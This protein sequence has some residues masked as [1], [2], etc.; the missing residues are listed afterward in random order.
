MTQTSAGAGPGSTGATFAPATSAPSMGDLRFLPGSMID[1]R[2]RIIGLLG[3]GG[4]G[5]VY[6]A[7]DLKLGQPVAL[8]FLPADLAQDED[9]LN[10]FL[11]EVK[12]ARQVAHPNVCRVYD[13]GEAGGSHYL[14]MEYV[15]GEDLATLLRRIG[16]LPS[17]KASQ[18]ARQ[19]CAGLAA[20]HEQG[21]LHR[22]IKP[23]NVMIDGQGRAKLTDF[24]LAGLADTIHGAEVRAGTPTYMAPEQLAGKEVTIQSDIYALG[25]VLYELFTGKRAFDAGSVA[26]LTEMQL[27]STPTRPSSF[28]DIFDP[29]VERVIYLCLEADPTARPQSALAVAAALPG[30]DPLAAALAAGETP[31]P[32]MLANAGP[33]GGLSNGRATGLL[34][35]LLIA[36]ALTLIPASFTNMFHT[37]PFTK[38]FEAM[39]EN[40]R[41]MAT[42]LGA[43]ERASY[44]ASRYNYSQTEY[45]WLAANRTPDEIGEMLAHPGQMTVTFEHRQGRSPIYPI[46]LAGRVNWSSPSANAGEYALRL[47]L[48]GNLAE[49]RVEPRSIAIDDNGGESDDAPVESG[50][51]AN[52]EPDWNKLFTLAGLELER[53]DPIPPDF[54]PAMYAT[55]YRSWCGTLPDQGDRPVF[56]NAASWG[57]KPVYFEKILES[58]PGRF[59][60]E[61]SSPGVGAVTGAAGIAIIIV[62]LV[63][64]LLVLGG[65]IFLTVRNIRMGRGDRRGAFRLALAASG[66]R[67]LAWVLSG[68]HVGHPAEFVTIGTVFCGALAFGLLAW[69]SYLAF[70][71]Y[72][73]KIW[74]ETMVAW[75]RLISG[76]FSDPLVGRDIL[77]GCAVS[78]I[79]TLVVWGLMWLG[80]SMG[81]IGP[82]AVAEP[83]LPMQGGRFAFGMIFAVVL[84]SL[85]VG[86][87]VVLLLLVLRMLLRRTWITVGVLAL[88]QGLILL[89]SFGALFRTPGAA[90]IGLAIGLI[91][92]GTSIALFLRFG[93]VALLASSVFGTL[94]QAAPITL[95]ASAPHFGVGALI[96]LSALALAFFGYR[97]SI[98]SRHVTTAGHATPS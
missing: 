92:I 77:I 3:K 12:I 7:D 1:D 27:S 10:R 82:L 22:D 42:E 65:G 24:G 16:R 38:S 57:N 2:Y 67:M 34:V 21:I 79:V 48:S 4:M 80:R 36:I 97:N 58:D 8:K 91:G 75:S 73:R 53:F 18:I 17:D 90:I 85:W 87:G 63:V 69:V 71:P 32:E 14:S 9:K 29:A 23:A 78:A 43:E 49:L 35:G 37:L 83:F 25:L 30:G 95:H 6:R 60:A 41:E 15:D 81:S 88:L 13:V 20:A 11:H 62:V 54:I 94:W 70:E 19:L 74:P 96:A 5:E 98:A 64:V 68:D 59:R 44:S 33:T 61:G 89:S 28:M 56:V 66:L 72:V 76:R 55:D 86:L 39:R 52:Q 45:T 93:L 40:A 46:G 26:E 31:S 50:T 84:R 51:A 47:D